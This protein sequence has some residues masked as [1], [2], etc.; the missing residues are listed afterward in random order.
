MMKTNNPVIKYVKDLN[1]HF[2][3][4]DVQ[5]ANNEIWKYVQYHQR[6]VNQNEMAFHTQKEG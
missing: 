5:I 4:E 2:S 1:R 3:K 6:N